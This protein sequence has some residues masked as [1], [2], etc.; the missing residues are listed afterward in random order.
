VTAADI[1]TGTSLNATTRTQLIQAAA[2]GTIYS[3]RFSWHTT[4][5]I[6]TGT[7]NGTFY[8]NGSRAWAT[9][10]YSGYRGSHYCFTNYAVGVTIS[11]QRCYEVGNTWE[12]DFYFQWQVAWPWGPPYFG[13]AYS[14]SHWGSVYGNGTT[15]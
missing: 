7:H 2:A 3:K 4:G 6:Y 1:L 14:V 13:L 10:P 8:Y 15:S 12:R 9:T 11:H 5:G